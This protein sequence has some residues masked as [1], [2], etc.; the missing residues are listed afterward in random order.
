[1]LLPLRAI[2]GEAL[3]KLDT[4]TL[5]PEVGVAGNVPVMA[6]AEIIWN[7]SMTKLKFD[8]SIADENPTLFSAYE[9]VIACDEVSA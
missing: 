5:C 4:A 6:E 9:A 8:V 7:V 1:M 2:S 3:P